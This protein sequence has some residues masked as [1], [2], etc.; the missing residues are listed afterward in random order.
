MGEPPIEGN[1]FTADDGVV[2]IDSL[3]DEFARDHTDALR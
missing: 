2:N 1:A 3:S